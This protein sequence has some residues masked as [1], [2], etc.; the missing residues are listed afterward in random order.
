[1]S[2][3]ASSPE[4]GGA[5]F[6]PPRPILAMITDSR[7]Y[8][9]AGAGADARLAAVA[10]AAGRAARAGVDLVQ[11]RERGVE[12]ATLL[13]LT[14]RVRARLAGTS[15]R[16]LVNDRS[17]VALAAGADGVHLPAA[18]PACARV[19]AMAP[20]PFLI[21]RSVHGVDEAIAVEAA[22]SCDY[23]VFGTVYPSLSKPAGHPVAGLEALA[24]VCAA[25][26]LPVLAIGG[27]TVDRL[28]EVAAAGAAGAAAIG[29]FALGAQAELDE[30]VAHARRVFHQC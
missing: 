5:G 26:R 30:T 15:A 12:A 24:R 16:C 27:I 2:R 17:D 23:L 7:L 6:P 14:V 9:L 29:L 19:R 20:A 13:D 1:M 22:G 3:P 4:R 28:A 25:V 21:G 10:A 8:D 18:A 11:V